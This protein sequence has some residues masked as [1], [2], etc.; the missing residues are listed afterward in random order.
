MLLVLRHRGKAT[1]SLLWAP[2]RQTP[3][4]SLTTQTNSEGSVT[5]KITPE[6]ISKDKKTWQFQVILDTH[7]GSL[8]EDLTKS[9]ELT[10]EK[11]N[12][13]LSLSWDGDPSGGH[14]RE[15]VLMFPAFQE[16]PQSVTLILR[17]V[18]GIAERKFSWNIQ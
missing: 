13:Q 15:G 4:N 2:I 16:R 12:K 10:D 3:Q 8:D 1:R 14:H 9:A 6:N 5:V 18:G 7:T 17:N 11:R